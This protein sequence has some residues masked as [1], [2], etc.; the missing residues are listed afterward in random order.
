VLISGLI[1][2]RGHFVPWFQSRALGSFER[3]DVSSG[4]A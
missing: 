1:F 3:Q 4:A 2:V